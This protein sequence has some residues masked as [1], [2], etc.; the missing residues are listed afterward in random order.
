MNHEQILSYL[1]TTNDIYRTDINYQNIIFRFF[2]EYYE[3]TYYVDYSSVGIELKFEIT[4]YAPMKYLDE[5][6]LK[7]FFLGKTHYKANYIENVLDNELVAHSFKIKNYNDNFDEKQFLIDQCRSFGCKM[8][9]TYIKSP[10]IYFH[11][12][13]TY[14]TFV[15]KIRPFKEFKRYGFK[16]AYNLKKLLDQVNQIDIKIIIEKFK[17]SPKY[18]QFFEAHAMYD[19]K[20]INNILTEKKY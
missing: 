9:L 4:N 16:P 20:E 8:M 12:N 1:K 11:D 10:G 7:L 15:Q 18:K 5:I 19:G 2:I 14:E 17:K 13:I 3:G 6:E